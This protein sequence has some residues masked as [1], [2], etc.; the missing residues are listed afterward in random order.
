MRTSVQELFRSVNDRVQEL[1]RNRPGGDCAIMCECREATCQTTLHVTATE[2]R[3]ITA[4]PGHFFVL[5]GHEQPAHDRVVVGIGRYLVVAPRDAAL[6]E[7]TA[8]SQV[9]LAAAA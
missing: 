9:P 3:N 8:A 4:I 7:V 1:Q 6:A 2:Y 5:P